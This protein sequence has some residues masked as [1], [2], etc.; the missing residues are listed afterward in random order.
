[1]G[2]ERGFISVVGIMTFVIISFAIMGVSEMAEMQARIAHYFRMETKLQNAA[3]YAFYNSIKKLPKDSLN[4]GNYK[5][6]DSGTVDSN[7]KY[8]VY[9]K[10]LYDKST[11]DYKF[12]ELVAVAI[13][14][15]NNFNNGKIFRSVFGLLKAVHPRLDDD[16]ADKTKV[17]HYE[18]QGI[19]DTQ[20]A[21]D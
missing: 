4:Y 3:E 9:L 1:M 14:E 5:L 12:A 10:Y 16:T 7:I 13:S 21:V 15:Q 18:L 6:V 11:K 2:N 17:D 8:E 19:I 20:N